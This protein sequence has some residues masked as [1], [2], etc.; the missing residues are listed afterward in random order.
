MGKSQH[1][2]K[3]DRSGAP[4]LPADTL[5]DWW[6]FGA[7]VRRMNHKV[8]YTWKMLQHHGPER[9]SPALIRKKLA[10]PG[11]EYQIHQRLSSTH[12]TG[13]HPPHEILVNEFSLDRNLVRLDRQKKNSGEKALWDTWVRVTPPVELSD[14]QWKAQRE[15][16][17]EIKRMERDQEFDAARRP[18]TEDEIRQDAIDNMKWV[19]GRIRAQKQWEME[20]IQKAIDIKHARIVNHRIGEVGLKEWQVAQALRTIQ[21]RRRQSAEAV[22]RMI[23][24]R[25]AKREEQK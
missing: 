21:E 10:F 22:D 2:F 9:L 1:K 17:S 23:A 11:T 24:A 6:A 16:D 25:A 3:H 20:K 12:R 7:E 13:E 14:R 8:P 5:M 18:L 19:G 15:F 4:R